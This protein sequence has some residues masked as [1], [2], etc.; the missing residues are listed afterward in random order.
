MSLR[1]S[2]SAAERIC[3]GDM[4]SA[5]PM[6]TSVAVMRVSSSSFEM[7]KSSTLITASPL[8]FRARKRFAGLRSRWTMPSPCAS[9]TAAHACCTHPAA[10]P[11]GSGPRSR[12]TCERSAPSR[13]SRTMKGSP[14][15]SV[16]TSITRAT[17]ALSSRDAACASRRNR[18]ITSG[19][20]RV[21]G[22]SSLIATRCCKCRCQAESTYAMPPCPISLSTRYL[23]RSTSPGW[24]WATRDAGDAGTLTGPAAYRFPAAGGGSR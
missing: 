7:P 6:P 5:E 12:S 22:R 8:R 19:C 17:C 11:G 4:Y 15:G 21:S 10:S 18:S 9:A 2:T 1:A 16:S 14:S 23:P 20:S 3:S 13:Y 24:I